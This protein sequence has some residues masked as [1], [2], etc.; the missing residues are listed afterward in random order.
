MTSNIHNIRALLAIC[1]LILPLASHLQAIDSDTICNALDILTSEQAYLTNFQAEFFKVTRSDGVTYDTLTA[2]TTQDWTTYNGNTKDK[3]TGPNKILKYGSCL[4]SP[5]VNAYL[6]A[7][8]PY[9]YSL[10]FQVRGAGLLKFDLKSALDA[11]NWWDT[12]KCPLDSTADPR[13]EYFRDS[14]SR[15][16]VLVDG[17]E[18]YIINGTGF[19]PI[20]EDIGNGDD[21][22]TESLN[23]NDQRYNHTVQFLVLVVPKACARLQDASGLVLYQDK[24]TRRAVHVYATTPET[25]AQYADSEFVAKCFNQI[26]LDNFEWTADGTESGSLVDFTPDPRTTGHYSPDPYPF[27]Q[28]EMANVFISSDYPNLV[29]FYTLDGSEPQL[30]PDETLGFVCGENTFLYDRTDLESLLPQ[31]RAVTRESEEVL[32]IILDDATTL[33]AVACE[34]VKADNEYGYKFLATDG[35]VYPKNTQFHYLP[36]HAATPGVDADNRVTCLSPAIVTLF[37]GKPGQGVKVADLEV[38]SPL[39]DLSTY[40]QAY[41]QAG[42]H[43]HDGFFPG[44]TFALP[45]WSPDAFFLTYFSL[46]DGLVIDTSLPTLPTGTE[47][48]LDGEPTSVGELVSTTG[49]HTLTATSPRLVGQ[50]SLTFTLRQDERATLDAGWHLLPIYGALLDQAALDNLQ[51]CQVF[52]FDETAGCFSRATDFSADK[53]SALWLFAPTDNF[54]NPLYKHWQLLMPAQ[55]TPPTG[56]WQLTPA[57]FAPATSVKWSW[58]DGKYQLQDS[59][60][61]L[62][63]YLP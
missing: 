56:A 13:L 24:S 49:E 42:V 26:W 57:P 6:D 31:T 16:V 58:L 29:F 21:W 33:R 40:D 59:G 30:I 63:W 34:K 5:Y 51:Q 36:A 2:V 50:F 37:R 19:E 11:D 28:D 52:T 8:A 32:G 39:P 61:A 53:P 23:F 48:R 60:E 54:T 10:T 62:W 14:Y 4:E 12:D 22:S 9:I 55:A 1:L 15:L 43:A 35:V 3:G 38:E 18:Q 47:L 41:L 20:L 45:T 27:E 7:T 25:Y 17:E 44:D 46:E